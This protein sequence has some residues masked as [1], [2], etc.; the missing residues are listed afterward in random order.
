MFL[1]VICSQKSFSP[2]NA[3]TVIENFVE[4]LLNKTGVEKIF[5]EGMDFRETA[6]LLSYI[7]EHMVRANAVS[8]SRTD[9]LELIQTY[10][11]NI[12]IKRNCNEVLDS[13]QNANVFNGRAGE[14]SFRYS[15]LFSYFIAYRMKEDLNFCHYVFDNNRYTSFVH[16]IDLYCGL[17][18]RDVNALDTVSRN[19]EAAFDRLDKQVRSLANAENL[20]GTEAS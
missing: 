14:V 6:D 10:Y 1:T 19:Y 9:M 5:R 15:V 17:S 7:V 16:E 20:K 4:A 2:I 12:G 11:R 3:S 18:R 13:L 8:V